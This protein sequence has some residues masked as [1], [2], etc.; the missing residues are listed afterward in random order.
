MEQRAAARAQHRRRNHP[1][2]DSK[3]DLEQR[4]LAGLRRRRR[5]AQLDPLGETEPQ[6][7]TGGRESVRRSASGALHD[8]VHSAFLTGRPS[9]RKSPHA[10]VGGALRRAGGEIRGTT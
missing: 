4:G 9:E 5:D 6:L 1:E 10:T 7:E 3:R 2:N 8:G